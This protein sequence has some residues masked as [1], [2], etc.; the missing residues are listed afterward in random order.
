[1]SLILIQFYTKKRNKR[2]RSAFLGV[3]LFSESKFQL[4]A[5]VCGGLWSRVGWGFAHGIIVRF[6]G[7][8]GSKSWE[9]I[10]GTVDKGRGI[11][12]RSIAVSGLMG[13]EN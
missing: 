10:P 4:W 7:L 2:E 13:T 9:R 12:L 5:G 8:I 6:L 3:L 11:E 1:M